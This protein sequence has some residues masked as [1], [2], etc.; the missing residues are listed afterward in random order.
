RYADA[1]ETV[2]ARPRGASEETAV[3]GARVCLGP[4]PVDVK[5][6]GLGEALEGMDAEHAKSSA[7]R[8]VEAAVEHD[9]AF[10]SRLERL[11]R[12]GL[13]L[14]IVRSVSPRI[15]RRKR[16]SVECLRQ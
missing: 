6:T 13:A 14:G 4:A 16:V 11:L 8:W 12:D 5:E 2:R 10:P 7:L 9:P 3:A 1:N 15:V